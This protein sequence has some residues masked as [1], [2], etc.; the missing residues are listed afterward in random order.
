SYT[1]IVEVSGNANSH[2]ITLPVGNYYLAMTAI[3][4]DGESELSGEVRLTSR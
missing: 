1:D 2:S 4:T 3:G